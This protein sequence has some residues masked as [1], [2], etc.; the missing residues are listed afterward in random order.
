MTM[1]G[2]DISNWEN[3]IN[4]GVLPIDFVICKATQGKSYVSPDCDR[5]VQQAIKRGLLFG[6]YHYINGAGIDAEANHFVN[7]IVG[8]LGKGIVAL[9][10]EEQDNAAW[11]NTAYLNALVAKVKE[12]SGAVPMI[13]SSQA[14]FPWDV[15]KKYGCPTWVAQYAN[16]NQTLLQN[17]P[18]NEGAYSCD[19]RQYSSA[20]RLNGFGGNLDLNKAYMDAARWQSLAAV[21]GN[22][23]P[24]PTPSAPATG[25]ENM[26]VLDLVAGVWRDD[27]GKGE[28]RK[29][30]LGSRYNEVQSMV[31]HICS[32]SAE[33]LAKETWAGKYRN[34]DERKAI[35]NHRWKDVMAVINGHVQSGK[36]YTVRSGDTLSGIASKFGTTYQKIAAK[37]D[38]SNPN[39]I[40]AGQV[41]KI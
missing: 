16:M 35:L 28:T 40:Y 23:Q 39:L 1:Q 26:D 31:N 20:G 36:T 32:A 41:L 37:N 10:Y 8:Y 24:T 5:Q 14:H 27:Y 30:K 7:S 13:Y 29:Q 12:L 38:I 17:N 21:G 34:G 22:V 25:V 11:G 15:A 6:V 19:I 33:E 18:W 4:V 3:G 2:I 9:D